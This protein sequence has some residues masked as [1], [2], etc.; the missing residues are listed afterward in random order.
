VAVGRRDQ[1]DRAHIEI[2]QDLGPQSDVAPGFFALLGA[3]GFGRQLSRW[4]PRC[5]FLQINQDA[6]SF[7]LENLEH[8]IQHRAVAEHVFDDIFAMQ[9]HRDVLAG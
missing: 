1:P 4:N 9:P 3:A 7:A 8:P 2:A 5:T 6:G